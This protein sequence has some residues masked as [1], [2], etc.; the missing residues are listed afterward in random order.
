MTTNIR[1]CPKRN[2]GAR[3]RPGKLPEFRIVARSILGAFVAASSAEVTVGELTDIAIELITEAGY[4][5]REA[6]EAIEHLSELDDAPF[7]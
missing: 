3:R 1:N 7:H 5:K 4:S 2:A 6:R